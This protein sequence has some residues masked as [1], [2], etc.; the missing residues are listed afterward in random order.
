MG[1]N[2]LKKTFTMILLC[3]LFAGLTAC[4]A[5]E[6][7]YAEKTWKTAKKAE[8]LEAYITEYGAE[9]DMAA[10][11][12]EADSEEL[13]LDQQFKATALLCALEYQNQSNGEA[14]EWKDGLFMA[15]Y[16]TSF[17][18]ADR[19]LSQVNTAGEEFWNAFEDAF[20]PFDC[21]WPVFAAT[22]KLDGDTLVKLLEEIPEDSRFKTR[23]E[24]TI[25]RWIK[26]NPGKA[27]LVGDALIDAGYFDSWS[28][29]D[30][31]KLY[32]YSSVNPYRIQTDSIEDAL[33]YVDYVHKTLLPL[34][35]TELSGN[36]CQKES[37]LSENM[38]YTTNLMVTISDETLSLKDQGT[39]E[40][41]EVIETEG[42]K[43]LAFYRNLQTEEFE[44][45]PSALQLMGD[46]M[47][48]LSPEEFPTSTDE[49]DY[50]LI[51]TPDYE[52][53]GYYQTTGGSDTGIQ[54]VFSSTSIDLYDASTGEFLH[55]LGN[56]MEEPSNTIVAEYGETGLR[57]PEIVS[58]DVLAFIYRHINEPDAYVA[59]VDQTDGQ[60]E[61]VP[62]QS[63]ILGGW[64]ITYYSAN[65][66][67]TFDDDF[68]QQTADDGNLYVQTFFTVT[69]RGSERDS[70]LP[71]VNYYGDSPEVY[72]LDVMN[73][74]VYASEDIVTYSNC[75]NGTG[76][77]PEASKDGELLFQIPAAVAEEPEYL[78][79]A[80]TYGNQLVYYPLL[81]EN[82]LD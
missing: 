28:A 36:S 48:G 65:I 3:L 58:P 82:A 29:A 68:R 5:K 70:F 75:L 79:I 38:Y 69:N 9:L 24:D 27:I 14:L 23:W 72:L 40:L 15:E 60:S 1:K 32:F 77:D 20:S 12:Q 66:T 59:L 22:R 51:L 61:L 30:F 35:E 34:Q 45:S 80:I 44:D 50:Y 19:F 56:I 54:Q 81:S 71:Y 42:K 43:V 2:F 17:S 11:Q 52:Y 63:I 39:E 76:I 18:Y 46:F 6:S 49:A 7:T 57:Y 78:Y 21:F 73:E 33:T 8:S 74:E 62:G 10:L 53:G 25:E 41:P 13:S 4:Q 55:H 31:R 16:P 37:S 64:E 47:L 67:E 26:A